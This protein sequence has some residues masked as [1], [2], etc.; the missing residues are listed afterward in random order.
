MR[1]IKVLYSLKHRTIEASKFKCGT[2][3]HKAKVV[4]NFYDLETA[5]KFIARVLNKWD[6]NKPNELPSNNDLK[7]EWGKFEYNK[8]S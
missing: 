5:D 6:F 7:S 2:Y 3:K 1:E 8:P 4:A